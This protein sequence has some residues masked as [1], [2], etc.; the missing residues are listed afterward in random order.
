MHRWQLAALAAGSMALTACGPIFGSEE[1][2]EGLTVRETSRVERTVEREVPG[3]TSTVTETE[4]VLLP[5]PATASEIDVD[6][7]EERSAGL[8][9]LP[10]GL[11]CRDL[12]ALGYTALEAIAYWNDQGHPDRLDADGNFRPCETVYEPSAIAAYF[13]RDFIHD[14]E[15]GLLCRDLHGR[16]YAFW[17]AW[18][19]WELEGYP[20]RMDVDLDTIPCETVY[21]ADE[22]DRYYGDTAG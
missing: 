17:E 9:Q 11:F 8:H 22:I 6:E 21:P 1:P 3:P 13:E 12:H 15:S 4:Y 18:A 7:G 5:A 16:G 14:V 2:S 10:D 19:Y 20:D